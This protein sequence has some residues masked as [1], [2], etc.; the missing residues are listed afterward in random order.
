MWL[1]RGLIPPFFRLAFCQLPP[2]SGEPA[3]TSKCSQPRLRLPAF[4]PVSRRKSPPTCLSATDA[5]PCTRVLHQIRPQT[6]LGSGSDGNST[7]PANCLLRMWQ[8]LFPGPRTSGP[9]QPPCHRRSATASLRLGAAEVAG[10][11][12]CGAALEVSAHVRPLPNTP[13]A[14]LQFPK[15]RLSCKGGRSYEIGLLAPMWQTDP[16]TPISATDSPNL[17]LAAPSVF[18]YTGNTPR[19]ALRFSRPVRGACARPHERTD[20]ARRVRQPRLDRRTGRSR[21]WTAGCRMVY[22]KTIHYIRRQKESVHSQEVQDHHLLPAT[23]DGGAGASGDEGGRPIRERVA[24]SGHP[25]VH[26]GAR[27]AQT[28]AAGTAALPPEYRPGRNRRRRD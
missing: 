15:L 11:V 5:N 19:T 25:P 20:E 28:G 8:R 21:C 1:D 27:V 18:V 13:I 26:G 4:P 23:G 3:L 7:A 14:L 22:S 24:P 2:S 10:D 6:G 17:Q 16:F 12:P 9:S